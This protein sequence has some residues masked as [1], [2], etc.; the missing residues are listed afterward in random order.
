MRTN[1]HGEP[2]IDFADPEA[3]KTLN[4]ALLKNQ[5][6]LSNWEIPAGYLCPPIPGRA[7]YIHHIADL[8][9]SCN[10]GVIP[11]GDEIRALDI[12]VGAN[13]IYPIVGHCE[14]GWRFVG[15]DI[16]PVA[17]ASAKLIVQSNNVLSDAVELRLQPSSSDILRGIVQ[18]REEFDVSICNPPFHASLDEARQ[19][20]R[21]KWKNLGLAPTATSAAAQAPKLNFGGQDAEL[22][23]PGGELAFVRRMVKESAENPAG[24]FWLSTLLSKESSL[25]GVHAALK[26]AGIVDCRMIDTAR[27]QKKSRIIAWTFLS[28]KQQEEWREKRWK[29]SSSQF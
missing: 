27:G 3:V 15:S 6:G 2:T 1:P 28:Q 22:W 23:Y 25:P 12:G 9:S 16:D 21:R 18:P 7:D 5:Y 8:L 13:C 19:G 14:Y 11:R 24:F 29:T 20:S 10:G 4:R 26:E 17:L